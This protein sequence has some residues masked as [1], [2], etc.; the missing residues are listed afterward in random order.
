[1]LGEGNLDYAFAFFISNARLYRLRKKENPLHME[2]LV[3]IIRPTNKRR[4]LNGWRVVN[5]KD[6]D[7]FKELVNHNF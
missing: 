4:H 5:F 2:W 6:G 3:D 1:M 7:E